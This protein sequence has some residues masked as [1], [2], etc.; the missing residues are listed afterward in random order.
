MEFKLWTYT[1][2]WRPSGESDETAKYRDVRQRIAHEIRRE[3]R[4]LDP[5]SFVFPGREPT[6]Q[7]QLRR[8]VRRAMARQVATGQAAG[9]WTERLC[10]SILA[11]FTLAVIALCVWLGWAFPIG[12]ISWLAYLAIVAIAGRVLERLPL[13]IETTF[14]FFMS[15]APIVAGWSLWYDTRALQSYAARFAWIPVAAYSRS[16]L[17]GIAAAAIL[18]VCLFVCLGI[19]LQ[20][21]A[22]Y[23]L[24]QTG[25]LNGAGPY[26]L[27]IYAWAQAVREIERADQ[28]WPSRKSMK[29]AC[30]AIDLLGHLART[31]LQME[32]L[33]DAESSCREEYKREAL[34]VA[35]HI[36]GYERIL[37]RSA[38]G[39]DAILQDLLKGLAFLALGDRESLLENLP[40]DAGDSERTWKDSLKDAAK[41][42]FPGTILAGAGFFLPMIPGVTS[43]GVLAGNLRIT[44][45]VMAALSLI[46]APEEVAKKVNDALN[47]ALPQRQ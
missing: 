5:D 21:M 41:R 19:P 32:W 30:G 38:G 22:R 43:Q 25:R 35:R 7:L 26:D 11:A 9:I 17:R 39:K 12:I 45:L 23:V 8:A 10:W 37:T 36:W 18:L 29:Q 2:E 15:V 31:E 4:R 46:S 24:R 14:L 1:L 28:G 42:I 3:V 27:L 6:E 13:Y 44:L 16:S 40:L 34:T 20:H 47:R 33:F